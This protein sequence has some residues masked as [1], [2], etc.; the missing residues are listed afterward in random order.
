[1]ETSKIKKSALES[2]FKVLDIDSSGFISRKNLHS[3]LREE[4]SKTEID[5]MISEVDADGDGKV[6]VNFRYF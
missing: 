4:Y 1:L 2:A 3:I 5:N 6:R